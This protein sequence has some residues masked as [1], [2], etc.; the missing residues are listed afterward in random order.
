M[1]QVLNTQN[2]PIIS[3]FTENQNINTEY[4][5]FIPYSTWLE[6]LSRADI[7]RGI[8]DFHSKEVHDLVNSYD[9]NL[10]YLDMDK[11]SEFETFTPSWVLVPKFFWYQNFEKLKPLNAY[12]NLEPKMAQFKKEPADYDETT[13]NSN[14][15]LYESKIVPRDEQIQAF[16]KLKELR[17]SKDKLF[18]GIIQATPGFGKTVLA[19]HA[20][21]DLLFQKPIIIV[22]KDILVNQ[23]KD[24]F[25]QFT[26]L[27]EED[28]YCLEGSN[29]EDLTKGI[30][31]SKVIIAKVQ[32]ILSQLKRIPYNE[33]YQ[34]YESIDLFIFDECHGSGAKGYGKVSSIFKTNNII[35]LTATPYRRGINEFLLTNSTGEVIYKSDHKNYH[36]DVEIF[37]LYSED[38]DMVFTSKEKQTLGWAAKNDYIKFLTFYN[39]FLYN[40]NFYFDYLARWVKYQQSQGHV[41]VVLFSTIKMIDKFIEY[42]NKLF[43]NEY[44]QEEAKPLK[45]IGNSKI[46]SQSLAK[47]ENK[48]LREQL[49]QYK[50][51]LNLKVKNKEIKRKDANE[52][53]KIKREEFKIIQEQNLQNA[54]EIYNRKIKGSNL[55][56]SNYGLLSAGFDKSNLSHIVFGSPIIG[57]VTLLQSIGRIVRTHE[58]KK[59]PLVQ[60]FFTSTFL[61]YQPNASMILRKNILSEF[62]NSKIIYKGF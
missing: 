22:P 8:K 48:K 9:E 42:Y 40:K 50:E 49:K 36:P 38:N 35:G 29:I 58:G 34:L 19:I 39:M 37:S 12:L 17:Y 30:N 55:L 25:L 6:I 43:E 10:K 51:E 46:D 14:Y 28:I 47:Q 5:N 24:A 54:I 57:K 18:R 32:S 2:V 3:N 1:S 7:S 31:N 60:F 20:I 41:S 16:E 59:F 11:I 53:Y 15:A 62:E 27:K 4:Q 33:L 56:V 23:W 21:Y 61:H 44:I 26:D 13:I 52:L 45:L